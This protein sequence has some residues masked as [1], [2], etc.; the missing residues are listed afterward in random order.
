MNIR[1]C[2]D[3]DGDGDSGDDDDDD[4]GDG[5]GGDS[6]GGGGGKRVPRLV[7]SAI[8]QGREA[9]NNQIDQEQERMS[10]QSKKEGRMEG[11]TRKNNETVEVISG[12]C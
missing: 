7:T 9:I 12:G 1:T 11:D 8:F 10:S 3:D 2:G 4:D 6:S 5:D